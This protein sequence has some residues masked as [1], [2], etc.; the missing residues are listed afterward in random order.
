MKAMRRLV[1]LWFRLLR[2]CLCAAQMKPGHPAP[3]F[4]LVG[5][6]DG[7]THK[8]G[9]HEGKQAVALARFPKA[10]TGG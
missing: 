3:E 2:G 1:A 7:M 6:C 5:F 9:H 4:A 10:F 8:L